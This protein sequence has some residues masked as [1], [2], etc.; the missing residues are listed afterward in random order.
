MELKRYSEVVVLDFEFHAPSGHLPYP[1]CVVAY[2]LKSGKEH[3]LWFDGVFPESP[4]FPTGSE[5]LFVAFYASAEMGCFLELDW[6]LPVNVIDLYAE[7]RVCTN[8]LNPPSGSSLLGAATAMGITTLSTFSNFKGQG[9][10]LAIRGG[11]FTKEEQ[12]L[13][14]HYCSTDVRTTVR[15]F[16]RMMPNIDED[17]ALLR[18]RYTKAVATIERVGISIDVEMMKQILSNKAELRKQLVQ[19]I[20]KD[21]GVFE[22]ESF[23]IKRFAQYLASHNIEWPLLPSG[24]PDTQKKTFSSMCE[25][26]PNL[27]PLKEL[28]NTLSQMNDI[29]LTVGPDA[30]NRVLLSPFGT[31]TGRNTPSNSKFIFGLSRWWRHLVKPPEGYG[32]AYLDFSYQEVGIAAALSRDENMIEAYTSG[33]PYLALAI[34][35]GAVPPDATKASHPVERAQFKTVTL[36][37]QYGM[38][39]AS[40]A[41]RLRCSPARARELLDYHRRVYNTFWSWSDAALDFAMLK[42]FLTSVFGWT[43]QVK[44]DT[45]KQTI[46]NFPMQANGAEMLR[47]AC[48]RAVEEGIRV[49]API[50][51]A[52]LIEASLDEL[53]D[54]IQATKEVM[55]WASQQVLGGFALEVDTSVIRYPDRFRPEG[56]ESIWQLVCD[57][58]P[59]ANLSRDPP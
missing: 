42:G 25:I 43:L 23:K 59:P 9:R 28:R 32:N 58:L 5:V 41:K 10:G 3:R 13:L 16:E 19:S 17:R 45:K 14:L 46:R 15:L 35:A 18:G 30:R 51:D 54:T 31:K 22:E 24:V 27:A 52:L 50:H 20:N 40:L 4:P 48:I 55:R 37:V 1:L 29:K 39:A 11:P 36:G 38:G 6:L 57:L 47:L 8:G 21:F 44:N 2:E 56:G 34:K 26:H 53:D 33:D 12:Q 49:C 7:F